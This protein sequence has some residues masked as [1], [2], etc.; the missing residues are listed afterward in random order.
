MRLSSHFARLVAGE[1]AIGGAVIAEAEAAR[2]ST[3]YVRFIILAGARTGSTM[4]VQALNS[5]SS[6]TCF[7]EIFNSAV[8]F[9]PFNVE[10]YDNFASQ[11]RA[12]RN[13]DWEAFLQERIFCD[14]PIETK[15]TGF[16]LLYGQN[17]DFLG[18]RDRLAEDS[19][20]RVLHLRRHNLLRALV[21]AKIAQTTGVWVRP[22]G[23]PLNG[24]FT[25]ANA[26]LAGRHPARAIASLR[27]RLGLA[28][29]LRQQQ[30]VRLSKEECSAMF[31]FMT[32]RERR[33]DEAFDG[34][35]RMT[36]YYEDLVHHPQDVLNQVQ[37]FLGVAPEPLAVSVRQ[38]SKPLP[39][40]L[41]NYNELRRAFSGTPYACF[42]D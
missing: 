16:K 32:A 31:R 6:I 19:G 2:V 20:L 10:G 42:F 25:K 21:S 3:D 4:L 37:T 27:R 17:Q 7:G 34:H 1:P 41:E 29:G 5:S 28:L 9:V 23:P 36:L 8:N 26:R 24:A 11:D 30:R 13:G 39:D 15:A 18:L 40:L 14:R 38:N 22:N 35:A 33:F 12:L